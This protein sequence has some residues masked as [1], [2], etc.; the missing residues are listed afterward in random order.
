MQNSKFKQSK[1]FWKCKKSWQLFLLQNS[2]A[3]GLLFILGCFHFWVFETGLMHAW[4]ALNLLFDQGRL[5][6]L[7]SLLSTFQMTGFQIWASGT[8]QNSR[9][10][11]PLRLFWEGCLHLCLAL[12]FVFYIF[13]PVANFVSSWLNG[14]ISFDVSTRLLTLWL[15]EAPLLK[16]HG[17]GNS[18][19]FPQTILKCNSLFMEIRGTYSA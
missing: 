8:R 3:L 13:N 19:A 10:T 11:V 5:N 15:S 17:P 16:P 2:K 12:A 6:A 14:S 18:R 4:L 7:D 9:T 1:S